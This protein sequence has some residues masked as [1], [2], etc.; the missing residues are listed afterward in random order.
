MIAFLLTAFLSRR[1]GWD[2]NV[3]LMGYGSRWRQTR[4]I[5]HEHF[6]QGA[7]RQYRPMQLAGARRF[8]AR[9]LADPDSF[10]R[11]LRQ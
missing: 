1:I 5:F 9:L 10:V 8:L 3:A 7:A 6:H 11:H 4:R 2:W